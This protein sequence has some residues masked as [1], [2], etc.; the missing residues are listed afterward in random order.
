MD[1]KNSDFG[2]IAKNTYETT[3]G[4]VCAFDRD[5]RPYTVQEKVT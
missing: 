2:K 5:L 3:T 4:A 1:M